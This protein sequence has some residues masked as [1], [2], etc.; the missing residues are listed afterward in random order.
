MRKIVLLCVAVLGLAVLG[1][2][3]AG[4]EGCNYGGWKATENSSP[5]PI[6]KTQTASPAIKAIKTEG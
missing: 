5:T 1:T 2:A 3:Y 6:G 4:G